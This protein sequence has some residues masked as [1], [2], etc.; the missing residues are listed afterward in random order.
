APSSFEASQPAYAAGS[1]QYY[2]AESNE[3]QLPLGLGIGSTVCGVLSIMCVCCVGLYQ[4]PVAA[5]G[6]GLGITGIIYSKGQEGGNRVLPI[7]GTIIS[8]AG[9]LLGVVILLMW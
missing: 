2:E 7:I 6:L 9:M 8:A 3:S 5:I 1:R 4:L